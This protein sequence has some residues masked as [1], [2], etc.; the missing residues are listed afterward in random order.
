MN[1]DLDMDR[2]NFLTRALSGFGIA[3]LSH[4]S[5]GGK[6]QQGHGLDLSET[7]AL[8]QSDS[9]SHRF[10]IGKTGSG[11]SYSTLN[12]RRKQGDSLFR[13]SHE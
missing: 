4:W 8:A 2:R 5:T 7:D 11:V 10:V 12:F 6:P 1:D 9:T 3:S 13:Q